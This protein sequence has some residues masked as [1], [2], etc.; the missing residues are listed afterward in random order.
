[1]IYLV[2]TNILLRVL[3]RTDP[4]H[5]IVR[6]AA[7][8]LRTNSHELHTTSCITFSLRCATA[9][10]RPCANISTPC[11]PKKCWWIRNVHF[12]AGRPGSSNDTGG[13]CVCRAWAGHMPDLATRHN[14]PS[15]TQACRR[16]FQRPLRSRFPPRLTR[17]V[18]SSV[19]RHSFL[20]ERFGARTAEYE[21]NCL[22]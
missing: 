13:G 12:M 3:H 10:F 17:G 22:H 20:R 16:R 19:R 9:R 11:M 8:T 14:A 2:D 6:G 15:R 7:R 21:Q 1:V 5:A 18:R 4:R